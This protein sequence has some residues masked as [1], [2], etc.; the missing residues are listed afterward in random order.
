MVSVAALFTT[1][2][3]LGNVTITAA[4]SSTLHINGNLIN[5][6]ALPVTTGFVDINIDNLHCRVMV[7]DSKGNFSL[8]II[9]CNSTPATAVIALLN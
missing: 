3:N 1:T 2:A 6:D 8:D 7:S 4:V 9:R 5:C